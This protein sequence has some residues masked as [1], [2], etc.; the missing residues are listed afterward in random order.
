MKTILLVCCASLA[1]AE[2][3][4]WQ[5]RMQ[6]AN[7]LDHEGRYDEAQ[8]LYTASLA[9]AEDSGVT[10]R[11]LAE[12][13]NNLA[14]HYF[15]RGDYAA[16]EPLYRRALEA[17]KAGGADLQRDLGLTMSNLATLYRQLG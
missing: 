15:L 1:W 17:W 8:A 13:L 7:R 4:D 5:K 12:S 11:W 14:A 10:G 16:A 9:E 2:Q 3:S 6:E